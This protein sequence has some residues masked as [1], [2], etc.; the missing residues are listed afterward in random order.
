[1]QQIR[2]S[3]CGNATTNAATKLL[4]KLQQQLMANNI[5]KGGVKQLPIYHHYVIRMSPL[6]LWPVT[7]AMQ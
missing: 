3:M 1:M 6:V 4:V 7:S 2:Y 5:I